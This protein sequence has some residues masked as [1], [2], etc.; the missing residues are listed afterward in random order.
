M[1][2]EEFFEKYSNELL[3]FEYYYKYTF[4]YKGV[5]SDGKYEITAYIGGETADAI[6]KVLIDPKKRRAV[7]WF[8][9]ETVEFERAYLSE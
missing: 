6:Y 5:T 4:G 1:T 2:R 7:N 9:S 3:T 8:D